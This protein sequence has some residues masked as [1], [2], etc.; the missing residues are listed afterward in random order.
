MRRMADGVLERDERTEAEAEHDGPL[1][2]QHR[3]ELV[4]VVRPALEAVLLGRAGVAAARAAH[5][6]VDDLRSRRE[7]R[8][9]LHL[10]ETVVEPGPGVEQE[11][12]RT[13]PHPGPV[14]D[15]LRA[16][17]IE[18]QAHTAYLHTH[19]ATLLLPGIRQRNWSQRDDREST[20]DRR[21]TRR[22]GDRR[23]AARARDRGVRG[24]PGARAA[25]RAGPGNRG[26][27]GN[28]FAG[29]VGRPRQRCDPALRARPAHT[30]L[31]RAPASDVHAR[32]RRRAT[33][34]GVRRGQRRDGRSARSRR[35]GSRE[36]SGSSPFRLRIRSGLPITPVQ[37]SPRAIS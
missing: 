19:G 11:H 24:Q 3:A 6:E 16:V 33:R 26:S 8:A 9:D 17:D 15:E 7:P 12:G 22:V 29:T 37:R 36:R 18:E 34:R 30:S 23:A 13:L 4:H 5:V 31:Q 20:R 10:E 25:L 28:R 21:G 1:D 35:C 2:P 27:G 32:T 14:G